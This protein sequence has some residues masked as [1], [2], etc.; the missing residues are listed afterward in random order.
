LVAAGEEGREELRGRVEGERITSGVFCGN[1]TI[2]A[3]CENNVENVI[4]V[5][6]D[7]LESRAACRLKEGVG[8]L[9]L[10]SPQ[11]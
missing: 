9:C 3:L 10:Q 7:L 6:I 8:T 5:P 1:I 11:A 4:I 2:A